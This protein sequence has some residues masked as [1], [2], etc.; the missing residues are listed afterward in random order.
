MTPT[1]HQP[2]SSIDIEALRKRVA[3]VREDGF[4]RFSIEL[5]ELDALL[6]RLERAEALVNMQREALDLVAANQALRKEFD[7]AEAAAGAV[8]E[9]FALVPLDPPLAMAK[10]FRDADTNG[11]RFLDGYAA[12]LA[13][14]P[15]AQ[16]LPAAPDDPMDWPLPCDVTVGCGTISKG[17]PLRTL[18]LRMKNMNDMIREGGS[19]AR[20]PAA[21]P[22][23]PVAWKVGLV[24]YLTREQAEATV[25]NPDLTPRPLVYGDIATPPAQDA[26]TGEPDA[27][28]MFLKSAHAVDTRINPRGYVW[29][30][31]YLDQARAVALNLPEGV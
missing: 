9:G 29:C 5:P 27:L 19:S 16:G 28:S 31:A 23:E 20:P 8:P 7:F 6:D 22:S 13:A 2:D 10:A 21:A 11:G 24:L 3:A 15:P 25:R 1:P 4:D 12:L 18:V 17:V 30:E 26:G 14:A